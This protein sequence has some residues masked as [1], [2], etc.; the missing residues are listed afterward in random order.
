MNLLRGTHFTLGEESEKKISTMKDS[1]GIKHTEIPG[2]HQIVSTLKLGDQ[3]NKLISSSHAA[4]AKTKAEPAHLNQEKLQD[5]RNCHF[6]YGSKDIDYK[7][8]A[9]SHYVAYSSKPRPPANV[10]VLGSHF[11]L[12]VGGGQYATQYNSTMTYKSPDPHS[13]QPPSKFKSDCVFGVGEKLTYMTETKN[14]F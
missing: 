3:Q 2:Q 12:G 9:Q 11:N 5:L 14:N 4:Y 13:F 8:E 6:D 1:Y 7:T 10:Q